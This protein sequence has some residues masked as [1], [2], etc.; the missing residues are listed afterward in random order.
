[1]SFLKAWLLRWGPALI[2]M[3]L[4][5]SASGTPGDDLPR[6]GVW[7]FLVKKSG[8]MLGYALL[9]VSYLRGLT[10]AKH[11]KPHLLLLAVAMAGLYAVTD[12]FHQSF[13]P[14][15]SPAWVDVGIDTF[16][17]FL[18]AWIW[19]WIRWRRPA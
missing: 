7:D 14:Q 15:R 8:H 1:M 10:S 6:F 5:F 18:G 4:I 2:M 9:A 19:A 13:T 3:A 11:V 17:A 16:G 12:E